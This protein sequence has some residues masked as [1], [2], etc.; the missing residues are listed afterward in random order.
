MRSAAAPRNVFLSV[1]NSIPL[2]QL[3]PLFSQLDGTGSA[4]VR[5]S[6][7]LTGVMRDALHPRDRQQVR[8]LFEIGIAALQ[9]LA[10]GEYR[11][12]NAAFF[13]GAAGLD[14]IQR[15]G[16]G[17]EARQVVGA[18]HTAAEAVVQQRL[19]V[20]GSIPRRGQ[21]KVNAEIVSGNAERR[22][23]K[24][25]RMNALTLLVQA[26]PV[27][28]IVI[29]PRPQAD[30]AK[31]PQPDAAADEVLVGVQKHVQQ[32]LVWRHGQK[33][34]G[35]DGIDVGKKWFSSS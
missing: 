33:A 10:L 17:M 19:Y 28:F 12:Q 5:A 11:A 4:V 1:H 3:D 6:L 9:I 7:L 21:V 35:F 14:S 18:V 20:D 16:G 25:R 15:D 24:R 30:V 29:L 27:D 2:H 23:G 31:L 13:T 32:M 8:T 22:R 26:L 34:V